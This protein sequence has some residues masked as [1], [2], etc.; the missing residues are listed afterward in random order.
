[1]LLGWV[2]E[3]Y[4]IPPLI[5]L[6]YGCRTGVQGELSLGAGPAVHP[7]YQTRDE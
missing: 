5:P 7:K 2:R 3:S 6:I 1:M 4:S